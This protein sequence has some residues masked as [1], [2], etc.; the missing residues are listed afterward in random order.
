MDRIRKLALLFQDQVV[1]E[2]VAR[3]DSASLFNNARPH[4]YNDARFLK[5]DEV[6]NQIE[7]TTAP[8]SSKRNKVYSSLNSR[9]IFSLRSVARESKFEMV[10]LAFTGGKTVPCVRVYITNARGDLALSATDLEGTQAGIEMVPLSREF[11]TPMAQWWIVPSEA[12][13]PNHPNIAGGWVIR[14]FAG[15]GMFLSAE[16]GPSGTSFPGLRR[17]VPP[18]IGADDIID[19]WRISRC[20]LGAQTDDGSLRSM[21]PEQPIVHVN[22]IVQNPNQLP[23]HTEKTIQ[24]H[25]QSLYPTLN[26]TSTTMSPRQAY[27]YDPALLAGALTRAP[28]P[29]QPPKFIPIQGAGT[30]NLMKNPSSVLLPPQGGAY[31]PR[32]FIP[33]YPPVPP[34]H[35]LLRN[36]YPPLPIVYKNPLEDSPNT[37]YRTRQGAVFMDDDS[38]WNTPN[39]RFEPMFAPVTRPFRSSSTDYNTVD[40]NNISAVLLGKN[41]PQPSPA[42]SPPPPTPPPPPPPPPQE[43]PKRVIKAPPFWGCTLDK[44]TAVVIEMWHD[45]PAYKAGLRPDD[46]II[47][48]AGRSVSNFPET[49]TEMSKTKVGE[50]TTVTV[51][52]PDGRVE[53]YRLTPLTTKNEYREERDIFF[54]TNKHYR[55]PENVP[56]KMVTTLP[57][58]VAN[59]RNKVIEHAR[60]TASAFWGVSKYSKSG[61]VIEIWHDSPM[62][63]SGIRVGDTVVSFAGQAV[64]SAKDILALREQSKVGERYPIEVIKLNGKYKGKKKGYFMT[65]LTIKPEYLEIPEIYYD[66]NQHHIVTAK[67]ND[68][69]E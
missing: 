44:S 58:A 65:P 19:V 43:P 49:L 28:S 22:Y 8:A 31:V 2:N 68:S 55:I 52:K 64:S 53:N 24:P 56:L 29:H 63:K 16:E 9:H 37:A 15:N 38:L 45:G 34:P 3:V 39:Q 61:Q 30:R 36:Q 18:N 51:V 13:F 6:R 14:S 69:S 35:Y 10:P 62:Y 11:D 48:V 25:Y 67:T 21:S 66:R 20:A 17:N 26:P 23:P 4:L 5:R 40:P 32:N 42:P 46:K 60:S 47:S 59:D 7:L 33:M 1:F 12:A 41:R 54:D 50:E 27:D 57:D